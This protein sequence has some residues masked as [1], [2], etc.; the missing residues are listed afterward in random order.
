MAS[1]KGFGNRLTVFI[2]FVQ[3]C[4]VDRAEFP[5]LQRVGFAGKKAVKLLGAPDIQPE[6]EDMYA[7]IAK[8]GFQGQDLPEKTFTLFRRAEA[9]DIFD[10]APIIPTA[11][12]KTRFH[13]PMGDERYSVGNTIGCVLR[14]RVC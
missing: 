11:I 8:P 5:L 13:R 10:N 14:P 9:K 1:C 6:L 3:A 4:D 2:P 12:K 7:I